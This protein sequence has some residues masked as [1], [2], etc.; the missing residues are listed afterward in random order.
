MSVLANCPFCGSLRVSM[1]PDWERLYFRCDGCNATVAFPYFCVDP[2]V[3]AWNRRAGPAAELA[4]RVAQIDQF[5][6]VK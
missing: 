4:E 6:R 3:A 1:R 5:G 2:N